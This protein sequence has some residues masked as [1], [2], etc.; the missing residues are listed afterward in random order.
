MRVTKGVVYSFTDKVLARS[1]AA[2]PLDGDR[3]MI[4]YDDAHCVKVVSYDKG[5]YTQPDEIDDQ[6]DY[7]KKHAEFVERFM[8]VGINKVWKQSAQHPFPGGPKFTDEE[9]NGFLTFLLE[10]GADKRCSNVYRIITQL[11]EERGKKR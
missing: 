7:L 1:I 8:T 3:L 5:R 9:I 2:I 10:G 6:E 4:I 11:L